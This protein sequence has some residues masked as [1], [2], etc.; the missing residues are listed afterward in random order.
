MEQMVARWHTEHVRFSEL[1][2]LLDRQTAELHE[3]ADPD[4]GAMRDIVS[5]L[6]DFGDRYH[7]PH[8]DAAFARM[9]LRDPALRLRVNRLLQEHRAIAVAGEMLIALLNEAMAGDVVPRSSIEASAAL[10]LN[11]YRHHLATE[12]RQIVPLA[13]RLLTPQDWSAVAKSMASAAV[14]HSEEERSRACQALLELM[15]TRTSAV[16]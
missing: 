5:C 11:Y 1:L 8:E 6:R 15:P 2:D 3:G 4:L 13:A 10:Y 14:P 12:E 9:V 7:H 16:H